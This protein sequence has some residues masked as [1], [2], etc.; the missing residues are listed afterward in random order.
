M[1][2]GRPGEKIENTFVIFTDLFWPKTT[3]PIIKTPKKVQP[4]KTIFSWSFWSCANH[5]P[6]QKMCYLICMFQINAEFQRITTVPLQQRFMAGLD[7][8]S[9]Q[10]FQVLRKKS[11]AVGEKIRDVLQPLDQVWNALH[12]FSCFVSSLLVRKYSIYSF[13]EW[14]QKNLLTSIMTCHTRTFLVSI[15][16]GW[17]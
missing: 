8:Q 17:S 13:L 4:G 14:C 3:D 15:K 16:T 11:G 10:L 5:M 2:I 1:L 6:Q 9:R 12:L 7:K